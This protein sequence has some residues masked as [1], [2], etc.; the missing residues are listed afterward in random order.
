MFLA[1]NVLRSPSMYLAVQ[2][3]V[4]ANQLRLLVNCLIPVLP[5]LV[6]SCNVFHS[7]PIHVHSF[8]RTKWSKGSLQT[9][10][11]SYSYPCALPQYQYHILSWRENIFDINL[12]NH[13][14][15]TSPIYPHCFDITA[16]TPKLLLVTSAK[17]MTLS[18]GGQAKF[19]VKYMNKFAK[20]S[21]CKLQNLFGHH[22]N[23]F[24]A[25]RKHNIRFATVSV[26]IAQRKWPTHHTLDL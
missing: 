17:C 11:L 23:Q 6:Q 8:S 2:T 1:H 26:P 10:K 19:W 18:T 12:F 20:L 13:A 5:S 14:P 15:I 24:C 22:L 7:C 9:S 25:K 21:I 16:C 3:Y 4:C